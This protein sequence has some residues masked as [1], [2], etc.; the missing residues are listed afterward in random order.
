V[1]QA[2][3]HERSHHD[4]HLRE[5]RVP[6]CTGCARHHPPRG[7]HQEGF[8]RGRGRHRQHRAVQGRFALRQDDSLHGAQHHGGVGS[9]GVRPRGP[10]GSRQGA[11]SARR[12]RQ[13]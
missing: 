3:G 2:E 5:P 1:G 11:G 12:P 13:A 10:R 8:L 6:R 7:L 4:Q 9:S